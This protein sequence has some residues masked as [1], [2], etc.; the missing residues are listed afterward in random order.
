MMTI[1]DFAAL[2]RDSEM[3]E[4]L[5]SKG[6]KITKNFPHFWY[7]FFERAKHSVFELWHNKLLELGAGI[8]F[9]EFFKTVFP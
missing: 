7:T 9:G 1:V 8:V 2:S 3:L 5:L 6:G 4:F